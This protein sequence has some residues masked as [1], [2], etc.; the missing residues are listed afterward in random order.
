MGDDPPKGC[1]HSVYFGKACQDVQVSSPQTRRIRDY[2]SLSQIR[3]STAAEPNRCLHYGFVNRWAH[4]RCAPVL[5]TKVH[6]AFDL[7]LLNSQKPVSKSQTEAFNDSRLFV[8]PTKFTGRARGRSVQF[9]RRLRVRI[10]QDF[11][12]IGNS[13][14]A[15]FLINGISLKCLIDTAS[16]LAALFANFPP[17]PSGAPIAGNHYL[18]SNGPALAND[19][20]WAA[21]FLFVFVLNSGP[22]SA[23][24]VRPPPTLVTAATSERTHSEEF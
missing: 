8:V 18:L 10:L 21:K 20:G 13:V 5:T 4:I 11:S 14:R 16:L 6:I 23:P 19:L 15:Y 12:K 9:M 1:Q 2:T 24:S 7:V 22:S 3:L 17:S